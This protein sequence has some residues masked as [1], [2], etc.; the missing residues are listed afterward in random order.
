MTAK[1]APIPVRANG[2]PADGYTLKPVKDPDQIAHE[3]ARKEIIAAVTIL[4]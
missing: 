3:M 4:S 2:F 1:L